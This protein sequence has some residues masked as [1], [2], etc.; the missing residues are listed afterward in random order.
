MKQVTFFLFLLL[1]LTACKAPKPPYLVKD[2]GYWDIASMEYH[3]TGEY[4]LDTTFTNAGEV[5]FQKRTADERDGDLKE[6]MLEGYMTA[7]EFTILDDSPTFL[8]TTKWFNASTR[9][10]ISPGNDIGFWNFELEK[11]EVQDRTTNS[12][13]WTYTTWEGDESVTYYLE[14]R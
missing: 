1:C 6:W 3:V 14:R 13:E 4:A 7:P 11:W 12:M 5:H 8:V 10:G 9:T 2:G